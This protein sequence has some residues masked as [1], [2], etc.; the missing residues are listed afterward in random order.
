MRRSRR[1]R[2]RKTPKG[3]PCGPWRA[4]VPFATAENQLRERSRL[5]TVT[6]SRC[7][8]SI[9]SNR[10]HPAVLVLLAATIFVARAANGPVEWTAYANDSGGSK[11]SP[12]DQITRANVGRLAVAWV[13][14]TGDYGVGGTQARDET[15]PIFVD[16]VLYVS[17]PFGGRIVRLGW[18][19]VRCSLHARA[20]S[21]AIFEP[22]AYPRRR[23]RAVLGHYG[24]PFGRV[25][26]RRGVL[27][28]QPGTRPLQQFAEADF[29]TRPRLR[30]AGDDVTESAFADVE[31]TRHR[32]LRAPRLDDCNLETGAA[33]HGPHHAARSREI[34]YR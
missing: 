22:S 19:L 12:A 20:T 21:C 8:L 6:D 28:E 1:I 33:W 25:L 4:A 14:R 7:S 15:T 11:Y 31:R 27:T 34:F 9:M 29:F 26:R 24:D 32:A 30:H 5:W 10:L 3:V 16:G 23:A 2:K 13:Y 18:I 17:T